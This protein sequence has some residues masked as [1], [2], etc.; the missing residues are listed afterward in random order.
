[1]GNGTATSRRSDHCERGLSDDR[2]VFTK[3]VSASR[4]PNTTE[5]ELKEEND[6]TGRSAALAL[7]E[8]GARRVRIGWLMRSHE[9]SHGRDTAVRQTRPAFPFGKADIE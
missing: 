9:E 1:M 6:T 8:S 3:L 5:H 7:A 4:Q 2:V